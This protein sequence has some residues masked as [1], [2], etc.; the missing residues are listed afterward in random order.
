MTVS[1][2]GSRRPDVLKGSWPN[3]GEGRFIRF[4]RNEASPQTEVERDIT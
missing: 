2:D 1:N 3:S 4:Q